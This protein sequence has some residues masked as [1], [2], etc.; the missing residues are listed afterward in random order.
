MTPVS[1]ITTR[2]LRGLVLGTALAGSLAFAFAAGSAVRAEDADP[3]LAKV[4]GAEIHQS[5][6]ARAEEELG[7]SLAQMDPA[8]KKE[9]V[10]SFLIDMKIVAKAAED[11]KIQDTPEFKKR[12]EFARN[13]LLMDDLLAAQGKAATTDEA[14][15]KVYDDAAKQISGEQEVHARHILVETEDEAKAIEAELKKGADFATLAK[16]KSKDPGASDGGDLGFF[17][18][19]QMVPEFSAVAFKLEPGQISDPVK[20]Q[21]GWHI[22]KVEEK[23]NRKPPSFD[24]VKPQIEQYVTRKAQSDYVNQLRQSAKI[25]RMDQPA[26]KPDDAAKPADAAK[27]DAA[28]P[29][30]A[31]TPAAKK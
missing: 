20:T 7:P 25:E 26:A 4:N 21:F 14:M 15:K 16:S 27:P 30:A 1:F 8:T 9:N 11:K 28:K 31:K 10:L 13:R 17:T 29:D 2:G 18:K 6:V 19:D 23:R 3:V 5:D 12:L 24:Q 22:I